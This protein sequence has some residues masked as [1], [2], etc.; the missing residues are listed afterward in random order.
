MH[1][2]G[3]VTIRDCETTNAYFGIYVKDR[4][5]GGI[6]ANANPSDIE[7]WKVVPLSGFGQTGNHLFEHN[8]SHSNTW[9]MFFEA[10]WDLG[11]TI[12]YNLFYENHHESDSAA[13][14]VY[15]MPDGE[16]QPGGALFFKDHL[17][18]P[19]AIYNNT[20]WHNFLILGA[21][22]RAGS[23]HLIFNNIYAEPWHYWADD[24]TYQN[25]WLKM[26]N[27]FVNR[28]KHCTYAA[29]SEAPRPQVVEVKEFDQGINDTVTD[30]VTSYRVIIMNDV[31]VVEQTNVTV[32][33]VVSTGTVNKTINGVVVPGNRII[34]ASGK[35]WPA[36]ANIRWFEIN[37]NPRSNKSGLPDTQL[38]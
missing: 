21:H 37:S 4:N 15:N 29:Q 32:P 24:P 25:S 14:K 9:G 38:G 2:A 26:D 1:C 27:V 7:P 20:F 13:K 33:M 6:F 5:E 34:G 19:L 23:Q 16:T 22:W 12:R 30:S 17:L 28:M 8:R 18:S 35:A 3:D 11:S 31:G 36:E 10:T